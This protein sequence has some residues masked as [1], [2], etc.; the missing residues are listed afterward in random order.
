MG[1]QPVARPLPT[2]R[3]TQTQ[4]KHIQ[5]SMPRV[6]FEPTIPVFERTKNSWLRRRGLCDRQDSLLHLITAPLL[7]STFYKLQHTSFLFSLLHMFF[8]CDTLQPFVKLR[9]NFA[10]SLP[11]ETKRSLQLKAVRPFAFLCPL[12]EAQG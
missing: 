2:P 11:P 7:I 8:F 9:C 1:D 4:N 12:R 6:G 10:G 3:K 5:T